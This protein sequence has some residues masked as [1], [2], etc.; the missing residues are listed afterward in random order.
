[1]VVEEYAQER[2][3]FFTLDMNKWWKVM[4]TGVLNLPVDFLEIIIKIQN[5]LNVLSKYLELKVFI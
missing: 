1:M 2:L 3:E 4:P 5:K